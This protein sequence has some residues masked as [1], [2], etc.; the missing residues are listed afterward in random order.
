MLAMWL[1]YVLLENYLK[2]KESD[3]KFFC[4]A[5]VHCRLS[6]TTLTTA[7][8]QETSEADEQSRSSGT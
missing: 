8:I 7:D 3:N 5:I 2:L 6:F 1:A 4:A